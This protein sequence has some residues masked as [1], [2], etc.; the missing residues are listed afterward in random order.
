MHHHTRVR[1][2]A[3]RDQLSVSEHIFVDM[4]CGRHSGQLHLVPI[5]ALLCVAGVVSVL[6]DARIKH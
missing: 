4:E 2:G 5:V 1:A 6:F 3:K